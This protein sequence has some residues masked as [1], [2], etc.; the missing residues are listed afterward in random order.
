M[1][2]L[3]SSPEIRENGNGHESDL[4]KIAKNIK[5]DLTVDA[6]VDAGTD[7]PVK[8]TLNYKG[9]S[10]I[11][12]KFKMMVKM[13]G[14]TK[15]QS[16]VIDFNV[17]TKTNEIL[18]AVVKELTFDIPRKGIKGTQPIEVYLS[19]CQNEEGALECDDNKSVQLS[20]SF[21]EVQNG[22]LPIIVTKSSDKEEI[23]TRPRP[24]IRIAEVDFKTKEGIHSVSANWYALQQVTV[25]NPSCTLMFPRK[26]IYM[27]KLARPGGCDFKFSDDRISPG[28][29]LGFMVF[30]YDTPTDKDVRDIRRFYMSGTQVQQV[31][32]EMISETFNR[33][34][35]K[36]VIDTIDDVDETVQ[37]VKG[38][39]NNLCSRVKRRGV[40]LTGAQCKHINKEFRRK[41]A[42]Y[43]KMFYN[44][45]GFLSARRDYNRISKRT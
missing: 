9:D 18:D 23:K 21:V 45:G 10:N 30:E 35:F 17:D 8:V 12:S 33:S 25:A 15:E 24:P 37:R 42:I 44:A 2:R 26:G 11:N 22:S 31:P 34:D 3:S 36:V 20:R 43:S 28:L 6:S 39:T 27:T 32:L 13:P 1:A 19:E 5:V 16:E 29:N 41:A 14:S 38:N 40:Y 7:L 4:E